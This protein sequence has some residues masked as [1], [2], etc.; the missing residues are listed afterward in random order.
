MANREEQPQHNLFWLPFSYIL[1][2]AGRSPSH[3]RYR[4][5]LWREALPRQLGGLRRVLS[6]QPEEQCR[7]RSGHG[8]GDREIRIF[9]IIWKS[10]YFSFPVGP[11]PGCALNNRSEFSLLR[12]GDHSLRLSESL[13]H[14]VQP[15]TGGIQGEIQ[16]EF[17]TLMESWGY[18]RSETECREKTISKILVGKKRRGV[19]VCS[20]EEF[21][22]LTSSRVGIDCQSS[23]RRSLLCRKWKNQWLT[24]NGAGY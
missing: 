22:Q 1:F 6:S 23:R 21:R 9:A 12:R 7:K 17:M 5:K 10:Q 2:V 19:T 24:R 8:N 11:K 13:Q 18:L 3:R 16:V 14:A 4:Q 20:H 15:A